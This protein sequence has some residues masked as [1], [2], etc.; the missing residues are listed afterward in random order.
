MSWE[1]FTSLRAGHVTIYS[2]DGRAVG[3]IYSLGSVNTGKS[4]VFHGY[5]LTVQVNRRHYAGSDTRSLLGAIKS[6]NQELQQD[7]LKMR[8]I[9][10]TSDSSGQSGFSE[11][12]LS[13][14][15]G[16]GYLPEQS[17]PVHMMDHHNPTNHFQHL[18]SNQQAAYGALFG[19]LAADAAGATLEFARWLTEEAVD[20]AMQMVGGGGLHTAPGQITDDGELT[21]ASLHALTGQQ[22][23]SVDRVASAY[24]AWAN[25]NPFDI[26][27]TTANALRYP[28]HPKEFDVGDS[29]LNA[30]REK[31]MDSKAN[32]AL[33]RA[34][35]LAVWSTRVTL[36]EAIEAAKLDC[37]LTH[38]NLSCQYANAA[39]VVA[40]RHLVMQPGDRAG[41]LEAAAQT[42]ENETASEVRGWFEHALADGD[43]PCYPLVGF[44]KIAF[45]LAF[46]HLAKAST[47]ETAI[48]ETL[49]GG[50]D[51]DTN[52]CIVGG[53]IGA[54]HGVSS[55]PHV[56]TQ[57]LLV[58]DTESGRPRPA[59]YSTS[60][61][62]RL[63]SDLIQI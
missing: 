43:E 26:G 46:K 34:T 42:L 38:P 47:Y 11:S 29:V 37:Q 31:N 49:L 15:T 52:A 21:L 6:C 45:T 8:V 24:V 25:S 48:T 51:T 55:I 56:M 50:G 16:W 28:S 30:A 39:Y 2:N 62:K 59:V 1:H 33:M 32:G 27:N 36:T 20:E 40:I 5:R 4:G 61:L 17:K 14:G 3:A 12:G 54:L 23:F 63:V 10:L 44:V 9:A 18:T 60:E 7:G 35:A 19:A 53:L 41:A 13:H 22:T 58:C 57:A